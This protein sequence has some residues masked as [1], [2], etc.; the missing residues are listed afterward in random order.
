MTGLVR[1]F[2]PNPN[3]VQ[4]GAPDFTTENATARWWPDPSPMLNLT[5]IATGK[6]AAGTFKVS[7]LPSGQRFVAY[8]VIDFSPASS[9]QALLTIANSSWG[10]IAAATRSGREWTATFTV[11]ADGIVLLRYSAPAVEGGGITV[12]GGRELFLG[13]A[14]SWATLQQSLGM[15]G[16]A[17]D[18]M[19]LV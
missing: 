18:M 5:P 14:D 2:F 10:S 9:T 19:P 15:K 12:H 6:Y 4:Q 16:F 1:N 3:L 13:Y 7:G 17:K 11:P 8:T